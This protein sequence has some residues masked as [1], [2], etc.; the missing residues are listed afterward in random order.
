VAARLRRKWCGTFRPRARCPVFVAGS[1]PEKPLA[2]ED[3]REYQHELKSLMT[4]TAVG[5]TA[6][7]AWEKLQSKAQTSFDDQGRP[8]LEVR[9]DGR[10]MQIGVSAG[11]ILTG[12]APPQLVR[13]LLEARLQSELHTACLMVFPGVKWLA[14]GRCFSNL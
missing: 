2:R 10:L 9:V 4:E 6:G 7:K 12:G 1:D 8:I 5:A 14:T 13:Q 11:N 3:R